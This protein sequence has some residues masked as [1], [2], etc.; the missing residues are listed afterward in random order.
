[1][2]GRVLTDAFEPGFL[3]SNPVAFVSTYDTEERRY[4]DPLK[5]PHDDKIK[6]KLR[7]VGYMQ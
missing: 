7:S 2:D 6:D 4:S 3:K 1:M 5:S